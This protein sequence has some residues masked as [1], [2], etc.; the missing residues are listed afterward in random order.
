MLYDLNRRHIEEDLLPYCQANHVTTIAYTPL[1]SGRLY[2][3]GG[4][5][6]Q[7]GGDAGAGDGR[8]GNQ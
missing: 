6:H 3:K 8:C 1:D 7:P 5:S 2:E 4:V